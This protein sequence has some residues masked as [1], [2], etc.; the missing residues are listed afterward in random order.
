MGELNNDAFD[1][2]MSMDG[3]A[4][5]IEVT[6]GTGAQDRDG[7]SSSISSEA[8]TSLQQQMTMWL[9]SRILRYENDTGLMPQNVTLDLKAHLSA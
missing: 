2:W 3:E 8:M 5:T 7:L 1:K 6:R 9:I 4:I